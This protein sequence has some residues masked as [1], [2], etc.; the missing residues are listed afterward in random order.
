MSKPR[1]S[2]NDDYAVLSTKNA[3]FYY[4]YE[5]KINEMCCFE[6]KFNDEKITIPFSKLGVSDEWDVV[7]CLL[8]GIG[9]ILAK[10]RLEE[11]HEL[12]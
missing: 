6:A 7:E 1:V 4:G 5:V 10:Y 9:L 8:S 3:S 12:Q 11:T 2:I